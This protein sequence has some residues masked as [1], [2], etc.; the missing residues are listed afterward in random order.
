[1]EK[2]NV[3]LSVYKSYKYALMLYM[4]MLQALTYVTHY[5][6]A[7]HVFVCVSEWECAFSC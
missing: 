7:F 1:M 5:L 6:V 4:H 2:L 3:Y